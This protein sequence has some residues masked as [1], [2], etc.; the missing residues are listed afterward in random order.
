MNW[1][2]L[3]VAAAVIVAGLAG[4][5]FAASKTPPPTTTEEIRSYSTMQKMPPMTVFKMV[6]ADKD[7]KA[8]KDEFMAF[9][10]KLFDNW[11]TDHDGSIS[12]E[13]WAAGVQKAKAAQHSGGTKKQNQPRSE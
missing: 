3:R 6:D 12:K 1:T 11:D 8:S 10:G 7:G 9:M 2:N 4:S 13:E 5:A